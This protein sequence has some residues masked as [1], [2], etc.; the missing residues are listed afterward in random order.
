VSS[1]RRRVLV[2]DDNLDAAESSADFLTEMGS[3]QPTRSMVH[4]R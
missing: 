2:V 1:W 4:R 3:R